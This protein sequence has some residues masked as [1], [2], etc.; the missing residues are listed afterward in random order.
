MLSLKLN[1]ARILERILSLEN[2]E[3]AAG[4]VLQ[5][6]MFLKISQIPQKN[7]N[8]AKTPRMAFNL[9]GE[10]LCKLVYEKEV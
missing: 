5:K 7:T 1:Y 8:T 3:A 2:T 6:K 10:K 9:E 4:S